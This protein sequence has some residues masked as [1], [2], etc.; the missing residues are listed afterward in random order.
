MSMKL[1]KLAM[2]AVFLGAM[3]SIAQMQSLR[4]SDTFAGAKLSTKE[5]REIIGAVE[6]SAYDTPDSWKKELRV[7]RVDLS[8]YQ[9]LVVQGSNLLCGGTGNC[10][11]WIFRKAGDRWVSMFGSDSAPIAEGFQ[12]GPSTTQGVKDLTLV[13]NSSAE[14]DERAVY[15]FDGKQYRKK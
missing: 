8:G 9:G 15:R 7:R 6:L 11:I 12:L 2:C 14:G 1:V 13:T 4:P 10:Q 5:A 3:Q